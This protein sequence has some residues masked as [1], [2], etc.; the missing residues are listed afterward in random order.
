MTRIPSY[1]LVLAGA[2]I[3]YILSYFVQPKMVQTHYTVSEYIARVPNLL[4][5]SA[6]DGELWRSVQMVAW[7]GLIIGAA[8]AAA[9]LWGLTSRR[10]Q[11]PKPPKQP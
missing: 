8:L 9:I 7:T 6:K 2:I 3:G 4:L 11:Q 5:P 10:P 1:F